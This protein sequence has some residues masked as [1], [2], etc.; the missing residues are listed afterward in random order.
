[1]YET[2]SRTVVFSYEN[3]NLLDH[4]KGCEYDPLW[5][6]LQNHLKKGCMILEAGAGSGRWL[7]FLTSRGY[8]TV[9][10]ELDA[11][12]VERF[13]VNFPNIQYDIGDIE[14]LPYTDGDFDAVLSHGVLEHLIHGPE[15]ALKE[16]NRVLK[17]DG[18][19]V[20]SVPHA[21]ALSEVRA[22]IYH[23]MYRIA[24]KNIFRKLLKKNP[25]TYNATSQ[26]QYL[27][28]LSRNLIKG[29]QVH[30]QFSSSQGIR[31]YE[32]AFRTGQFIELVK[33][34]GLNPVEIYLEYSDQNLFR[35]FGSL[36]GS[37][38]IKGANLNWLGT[39]IDKTIPKRYIAGMVIVIAKKTQRD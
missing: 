30:L 8:N 35:V 24:H 34:S 28:E 38:S 18:T 17:N 9:G 14:S 39:L 23:T 25:V 1:M 31:F 26:E 6:I 11:K 36:V 10:I 33:R 29:L 27:A 7:A 19:A 12:A 3:I 16:M 5:E 37:I 20:I 22:L 32:Y 21:N 2:T 15:R 4:I 13:H